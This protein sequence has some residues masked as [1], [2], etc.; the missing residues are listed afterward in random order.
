VRV[1]VASAKAAHAASVHLEVGV[2]GEALLQ[3]V[4]RLRG[5]VRRP[6]ALAVRNQPAEQHAG[7]HAHLE[8]GMRMQASA[9]VW[10]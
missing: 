7:A 8:E 10:V 4:D 2:G 6:V 5:D 3:L 1:G 9:S